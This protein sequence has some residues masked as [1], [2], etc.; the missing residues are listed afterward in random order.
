MWTFYY[1]SVYSKNSSPEPE[2][3]EPEQEEEVVETKEAAVIHPPPAPLTAT[4]TT[5]IG[6]L[7]QG[8]KKDRWK[9]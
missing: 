2:I 5:T 9:K 7:F 8:N 6:K 3:T 1:V 4:L